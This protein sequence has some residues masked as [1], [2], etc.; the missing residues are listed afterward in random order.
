LTGSSLFSF[1]GIRVF[2]KA[3]MQVAYSPEERS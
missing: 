2:I 3:L 1:E